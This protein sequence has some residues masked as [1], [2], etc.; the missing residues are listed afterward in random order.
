MKTLLNF[1]FL[2][3]I[4]LNVSAQDYDF[5]NAPVN[6]LGFKYKK[7]HFSLKGDIYASEGKI[8]D[9]KGNLVYNFGTR[10][11]YDNSGKIIGNNY[12]DEFEYDSRGNITKHKYKSGSEYNYQFNDKNLLVYEKNTYGEE[13]TYKYDNQNRV[14]ELVY[15]KKGVLDQ[16]KYYSYENIGDKVVVSTQYM[17]T[18]GKESYTKKVHYRNGSVV[19]EELSSGI[20]DYVVETDSRG[21]KSKLYT[22]G[23]KDTSVYETFNR[24]Y[25]DINKPIN[26]ELGYYIPGGYKTGNKSEAVYINGKHA[27]D[28]AISKG[29]KPDEKIIYDG[30]T[31]TYYSVPNFVDTNH[32]LDT[33]VT[34]TKVL[35]KGLPNISYAYDGNFIN[36][37][38][39]YNRVKSREFSFLGPH[40]VDYRV[41]K[42]N[43]ITYVIDNYNNIKHKEI[44]PMRVFTTDTSSILY[45]RNLETDNFFIVVKGKHIDYKK[46]RF[47]Y[48]KNGDP[49]IFIDDKPTYV[50]TGFDAAREGKVFKGKLYDNELNTETN[51]NSSTQV[52]TTSNNTNNDNFN[53]TGYQ[54]VEGDC[55]NGWGKIKLPEAVTESTFSNS[56]LNGVTYINYNDGGSYHG[57]Y[58]NNRREGT[59]FYRWSST[60]NTYIGQWKDGKQHGYGYVVDKY[61]TIKSIGKYENGKFV[62]DLGTDYNTNKVSGNCVGDCSNGFGKYTYNNGDIYIGFFNNSYRSYIGTYYWANKSTYTGTYTTDGKRNGYGKYT[63]VDTSVFKG[64]FVNDKIEG[65]G[66]M[67]YAKSGNV[68]NGVFDNKGA[69]VKDY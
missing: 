3:T 61:G 45:N 9:R 49:V 28:I 10:Y 67:Q 64:M 56:A 36:Y 48:L 1:I 43:G 22:A 5:I 23:E 58:K 46:A 11:Y 26:I 68:I 21:N 59:G 50:L 47:E 52:T 16:T 41:D 20:Y 65:L 31:E 62:T 30:L 38:E 37:V 24:Y 32:T 2:A 55:K 39:G 7:E 15:K 14:V 17:Y 53:S 19:K 18:N 12:D 69:K 42:S 63:Y 44:K 34:V 57:E 51:S 6:P 25:S 54:C 4:C 60:G 27:K 33:R 13:K 40:M 66:K 35:S 8:F 29:I